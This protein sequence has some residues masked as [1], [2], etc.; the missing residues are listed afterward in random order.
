MNML[1]LGIYHSIQNKVNTLFVSLMMIL[2]HRGKTQ[3]IYCHL[4]KNKD[5]DNVFEFI[6]LFS[7]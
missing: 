2:I 3:Q 6:G 4:W 7:Q 1:L 5:I